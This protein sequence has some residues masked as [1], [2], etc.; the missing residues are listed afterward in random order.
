MICFKMWEGVQKDGSGNHP[1]VLS[2]STASLCYWEFASWDL[3]LRF[4]PL[5]D[6]EGVRALAACGVNLPRGCDGSQRV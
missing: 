1:S 6:E 5:Q 3:E 2:S 4:L